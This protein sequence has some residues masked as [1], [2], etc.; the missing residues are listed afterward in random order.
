MAGFVD[1]RAELSMLDRFVEQGGAQFVA[2]YGRR[3]VGKTTLLVTW[4]KRTGLPTLYWVAKRDPK[5]MLMADL[6]RTVYAWERGLDQ[7]DIE[8]HPQSWEPVFRMI[9]QAVGTQPAIVILDELPYALE[10]DAG[11]GS[12]LQAAWDHMFKE[13]PVLLFLSGSHVGMM[14]D[15]VSYQAPLY[16]R[17]TAQLPV[18]PLSFA[19][20]R[21][22]LPHYDVYRRLAVYAILGGVPAY[23]ERWDDRDT[24]S[25]NLERLF[26][27]RTGWFRNE[28]LVLVS[29]LT[30]REAVS[31]E[32]ILKAISGGRHSRQEIASFA[33]IPAPSLSHYL[34]RLLKLGLVERRVPA[35]VP[36]DQLRKSKRSRYYVCDPF[37]RFYYRFVDPN[38]HLI[39]HG[40]THRLWQMVE[41][42][43][44]A[45]VALAFEEVCLGWTRKQAQAGTLPFAPDN[46]GMHWSRDVQVDVVAIAWR[47]KQILL[48]EC[49]WGD[50]PV[51]RAVVTDLIERKTPRVLRGLPDKGEGWTVHYALFGR[52]DFTNPAR[53][54]ATDSGAMLLTLEQIERDLMD[55]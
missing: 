28:P 51:D 27:Q 19:N 6:A 18:L 43:F 4:A 52:S 24:L 20:I 5:S 13:R 48:G 36:L 7:T 1:R 2:V 31:Y 44:R 40:L 9:A 34:P 10:Q 35:T 15:L 39:E 50:S 25:A 26:L 46:V 37:L 23:L 30:Q 53:S 54:A 49:K 47:E 12:H 3:R 33:A 41:D 17:L 55:S 16:G 32:A 42:S 29:D 8:I 21:E 22:F 45:F 14:Q 11:L 38:L